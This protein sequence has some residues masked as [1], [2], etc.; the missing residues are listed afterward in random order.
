MVALQEL[1]TAQ[2]KRVVQIREQIE[3]LEQKLNALL[4][5]TA[6]KGRSG[7]PAAKRTKLAA[8]Q[9][10]IGAPPKWRLAHVKSPLDTLMDTAPT[11]KGGLTAAG[12][13][14]LAA[15]TKAQWK[16][17]KKGALAPNAP[18]S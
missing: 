14:K 16:A 15:A 3:L 11:K 6:P 7:D 5:G 17:R 10:K 1:T 8:G 4:G 9:P 13:A 2:L 18:A 12:R